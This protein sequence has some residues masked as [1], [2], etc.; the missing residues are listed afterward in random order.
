M[1]PFSILVLFAQDRLGVD[2]V[3]YGVILA[4]SAL[5]GLLGSL[6]A[7]RVRARRGYRWTV[8]ASLL[9][10]AGSLGVLS[11]TTNA[12]VAA[13]LLAVYILHAVVWGVCVTSIRQRRVPDALRGRVNAAS[14]VL[15]L[16]GIAVGS[17][18]GGV[19]ATVDVALP[20]A[21]GGAVFLLCAVGAAIV[22]R[23]GDGDSDGSNHL[24]IDG[25]DRLSA[26]QA[27]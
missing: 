15:G 22:L 17:A 4:V 3:G 9:A 7:A 1:L 8:V 13:A 10:G 16:L 5:G 24:S 12:F 27:G 25:R 6:T 21:V 11:L 18:L 20:V 23:H 19:L 2:G 14:Q 26:A